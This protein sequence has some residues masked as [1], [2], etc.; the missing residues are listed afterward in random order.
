[1][2]CLALT[3]SFLITTISYKTYTKSKALVITHGHEDHIGGYLYLLKQAN[4]PIYAGPLALALI[5]NKLDEHGLLRDAVLNEINEDTVIRF[6]KTSVSFFRTTHSIP[7]ALGVVVKTPSGNIVAAGDFKVRFYTCR[8][9]SK[10][11]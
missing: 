2:N 4:I 6:R 10:F 8:R 1:M 3:T 9:T 5:T 7:D 11:A